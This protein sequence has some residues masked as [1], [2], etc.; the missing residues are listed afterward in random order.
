MSECRSCKY[1]INSTAGTDRV[2]LVCRRFPPV[3]AAG[4]RPGDRDVTKSEKQ[5]FQP[6]VFADDSCGEWVARV[7]GGTLRTQSPF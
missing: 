2:V 7:G 1:A 6:E 5:S 4:T 3:Q